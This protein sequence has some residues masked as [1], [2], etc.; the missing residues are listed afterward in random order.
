MTMGIFGRYKYKSSKLKLQLKMAVTRFQISA[1]KKSAIKKQQTREI[2]TLLADYPPKEE[3]ARIK[4]EALIPVE[5]YEILQLNCQ[6]LSERIH[7][8]SQSHIC[9]QNLVSCVSTVIWASAV[10]DIPELIKVR[11]QF[12]YKYAEKSLMNVL[13][14]I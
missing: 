13:C 14:K 5:A 1:N 9:P 10:V 11:K 12:K 2:T 4:A 7:L 8:L 3:E 6:L